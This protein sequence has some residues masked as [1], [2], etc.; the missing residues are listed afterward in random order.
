MSIC[1]STIADLLDLLDGADLLSLI[2][3]TS[4]LSLLEG[5]DFLGL[6]DSAGYFT[7]D[8]DW[9]RLRLRSI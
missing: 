3:G 7:G 8:R 6:F 9:A 2:D 4:L 5:T 1:R